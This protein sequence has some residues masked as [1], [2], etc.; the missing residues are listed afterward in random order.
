VTAGAAPTA[1]FRHEAVLYEGIDGFLDAI[2]PF[3]RE[4]A[5]RDEPMLVAVDEDKIARLREALGVDA[6]AVRFA[7]MRALGKNPACIIPAWRDFVADNA[8]ADR[9][10]RGVG[11]PIWA[12]RDATELDE[13]HRHEALLN[14][15]FDGGPAWTLL[16][17]YDTAA[18]P[19]HVIDDARCTHPIVASA[20][21]HAASD[22]Y[23]ARYAETLLGDLPAPE[24]QFTELGYG[25]DDLATVRG[26]VEVWARAAGLAPSRTADLV[27]AVNELA[28]N[29]IRHGGGRG[30]VR[31]WREGDR[32]VCEVRDAGRIEDPL[33][34][35]ELPGD[36]SPSGR[37]MWLVNQVC[38][39]VQV[40]ALDSGAVARLHMAL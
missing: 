7:E 21:A 27:L 30:V 20:G 34:G 36:E 19:A 22:T 35:R 38:D 18:L 32:F 15:A 13:C 10:M 33:I 25:I 40:R 11:E 28:S 12:G 24:P 29:S 37:G 31:S 4:G 17:P 1:R 26:M 23:R 14:T 8:S 2:V 16:C 39:L 6:G 5:V 9:P 3:L